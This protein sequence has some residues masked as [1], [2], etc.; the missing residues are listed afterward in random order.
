MGR[1][2]RSEPLVSRRVAAVMSAGEA[3]LGFAAGGCGLA[4]WGLLIGAGAALVTGA[5]VMGDCVMRAVI[6]AGRS[7]EADAT[8]WGAVL[9][10]AVR[11]TGCVRPRT[12]MHP[13]E[14]CR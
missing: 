14:D 7:A 10:E 9:G 11:G 12:E 13:H 4:G 5:C 2:L 6:A 8:G 3:G 1:G